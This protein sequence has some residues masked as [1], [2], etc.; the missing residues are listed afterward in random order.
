M[1]DDSLF[2]FWE[3]VPAHVKVHPDDEPVFAQNKNRALDLDC[4]PNPYYGP[5]KTSPIV[6]LYL[7]PGFSQKDKAEAASEEGHKFYWRQRQGS[8]PLRSQ[9][10][11]AKKS[12][13]VSRTKRL[14]PD[15]EYL[16][17]KLAV[18]ELCAYHSKEFVDWPLLKRLPSSQAALNWA[19]STLFAQARA[20]QRLVVC[21]RS[22]KHWG[23]EIGTQSGWL[24][25]PHVTRSGYMLDNDQRRAIV[26]A[27]ERV[28]ERKVQS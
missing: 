7:N 15:P 8:E 24:F 17:H 12:W 11:V 10:D 21:L 6:L 25:A 16:R 1:T 3:D 23:L 4:L 14:H 2:K 20:G 28:L 13:W 22:A 18:L 9:I 27:A 19:T 26:D 5:L